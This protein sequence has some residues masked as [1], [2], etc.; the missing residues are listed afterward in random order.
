MDELV[1]LVPDFKRRGRSLIH[2]VVFLDEHLE[3][4]LEG[5]RKAGL[6]LEA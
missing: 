6:E 5:L 3:M 2:R 4:L 1:A